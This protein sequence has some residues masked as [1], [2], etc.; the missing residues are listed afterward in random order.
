MKFL[1]VA[2]LVGATLLP[3]TTP[4]SA[5]IEYPWCIIYGSGRAGGA[6]SCGFVTYAQ[7]MQTRVGTDMCVENPRYQPRQAPRRRG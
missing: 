3:G 2:A 5:E 1:A 4:A 6:L 7:C